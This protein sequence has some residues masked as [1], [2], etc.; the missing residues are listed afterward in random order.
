MPSLL[1]KRSYGSVTVFWLDQAG[2]V[3]ALRAIAQR[4]IG[5]GRADAVYL[6]GSLAARR[7]VPGSDV[8]VLIVAD[9][10]GAWWERGQAF[11]ADFAALPLAVDII[12]AGPQDLGRPIVQAGLAGELLAAR[13]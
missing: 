2:L 9:G 13:P 8:D 11:E 1:Q 4:I 3:G 10:T 5:E 7:A 12:V 6:F